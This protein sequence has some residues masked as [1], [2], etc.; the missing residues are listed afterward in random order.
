MITRGK[1]Q[2]T[3]TEELKLMFF[4]LRVENETNLCGLETVLLEQ[5]DLGAYPFDTEI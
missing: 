5:D 3:S 4:C 1:T 2:G